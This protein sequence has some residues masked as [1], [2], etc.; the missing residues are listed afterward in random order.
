MAGRRFGLWTDRSRTAL[1][2]IFE[3]LRFFLSSS[4][5]CRFRNMFS[6]IIT[7]ESTM[8]PKSTAPTDN[9]FASSPCS[10]IMMTVK[11]S[12]KGILAPTITALRRL[13]ERP[14]DQEN[15]QAAED[16]IVQDRIGGY[17]DQRAAVIKGNQLDSR[18]QCPV[19]VDLSTSALTRPGHL[20]YAVCGSSP[21]W[22]PPRRR[23]YRG[24]RCRVS[25][26]SPT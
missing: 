5:A 16:E 26:H 10:T 8:M 17:R 22:P 7:A 18:R 11:N 20:L 25:A 14:L 3:H 12:A 23:P 21:R 4:F 2:K 9:R 1:C 24:R 13:P 15:E 6:T 19:A